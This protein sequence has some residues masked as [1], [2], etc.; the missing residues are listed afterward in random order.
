M[1]LK[2]GISGNHN[3]FKASVPLKD[4]GHFEVFIYIPNSK[5]IHTTLLAIDPCA[6]LN[7]K[8]K[9]DFFFLFIDDKYFCQ[10]EQP[11]Y[12]RD[13]IYVNLNSTY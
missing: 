3:I 13:R 5:L 2:T 4:Q 11:V 9:Y 8:R 10:K 12:P 1:S 7:D 6:S